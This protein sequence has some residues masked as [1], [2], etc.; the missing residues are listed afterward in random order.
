MSK[1]LLILYLSLCT[2]IIDF[3]CFAQSHDKVNFDSLV[4]KSDAVILEDITE[5]EI[6]DN[7]S[8]EYTVHKKVLIKNN[9][10]DKYCRVMIS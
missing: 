4:L 2:L 8:A 6:P 10:A 3:N 9:K 1:I 5:V 7:F